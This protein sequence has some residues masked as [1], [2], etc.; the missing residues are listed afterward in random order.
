MSTL[1]LIHASLYS[2]Q[3]YH[4]T[5]SKSQADS[6]FSATKTRPSSTTWPFSTPTS[7]TTPSRPARMEISIFMLS[8]TTRTCHQHYASC[9][10][11]FRTHLTIL[12]LL[13]LRD[14]HLNDSRRHWRLQNVCGLLCR[15]LLLGFEW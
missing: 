13:T 1:H 5:I 7:P 3:L 14:S 6:G 15:L 10:T 2:L 11:S 4:D 8:K 12:N 9:A